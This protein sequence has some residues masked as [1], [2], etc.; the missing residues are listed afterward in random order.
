MIT[1]LY[2]FQIFHLMNRS[3][4]YLRPTSEFGRDDNLLLISLYDSYFEYSNA[5]MFGIHYSISPHLPNSTP[6][7]ELWTLTLQKALSKA[8]FISI[9]K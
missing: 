5:R 6:V 7:P 3:L 2:S 1:I 8:L 9:F 4:R